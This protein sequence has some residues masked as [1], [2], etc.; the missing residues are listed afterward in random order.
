MKPIIKLG[1]V[2]GG[3]LLSL[4]AAA[5]Q[6]MEWDHRPLDIELPVAAERLVILD[7]NVRVGLP[8]A[9]ADPKCCECRVPAVCCISRPTRPSIRNVSSS[10]MPS[11]VSCCWST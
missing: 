3:C 7:R 9:I 8:R 10:R 2:L 5:V 11:R 1:V 4:N 6:I